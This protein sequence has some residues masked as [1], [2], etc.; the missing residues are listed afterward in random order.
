MQRKSGAARRPKSVSFE[1]ARIAC[2]IG[3][4]RV[5]FPQH[6]SGRCTGSLAP[7]IFRPGR[8]PRRSTGLPRRADFIS[9]FESSVVAGTTTAGLKGQYSAENALGSFSPEP[10]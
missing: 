5:A 6:H 10:G 7:S 8:F 1:R 9:V 3:S 4:M 2:R